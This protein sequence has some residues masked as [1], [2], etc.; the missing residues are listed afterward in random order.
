MT[1]AP[2]LPYGRQCLD[3]DDIAA[4][5][6][7]LR[8]D[9]LTGGPSV[10]RFE[11]AVA[12]YVGAPEGVACSNGTAGLHLAML[13]LGI[14]PGDV[15]VV[16]SLTFLA[17]ANA[18][19]YVGAEVVFADVDPATGLTSAAHLEAALA[20]VAAGRPRVLAPVHLNG[21]C[22]EMGEVGALARRHGLRV[23]ED[24]CHAIGAAH[25]AADGTVVRVGAC[26]QSDMAVFSMHPVKTI[27]MGEG[28]VVTTRDAE[29]AR[30]LRRFRSHGMI[31]AAE[32]VSQPG[33]G[34]AADGQPNSWYYEMLEPGFNYRATDIQC[35][36][37]LS[38]LAKIDRFLARRQAL[39]DLYDRLLAPL[40]PVVAP[41]RRI[42][43]CRPGWH[44][45]VVHIDFAALG[46]DRDAVMRRLRTAGIGTQVHYLPV[47]RQPYY[48]QRYPGTVLPGADAYYARCLSLP[49]FPAMTDGDAERVAAALAD[50][51]RC[52]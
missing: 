48:R 28:S 6:A 21:Q 49:L 50:L 12:A 52:G 23:V 44:L 3:E 19:R 5:A 4:V 20:R 46:L 29:L 43:G 38:Q 33:E 9:W 39:V 35:A 51:A 45:Y 7:V 26:P 34:L 36:L 16:P 30:R 47:H 42:P 18:A 10:A 13:A 32:G 41:I 40:A 25:V 31:P 24:A 15:V 37:G 2:F 8:G 17:T 22:V 14:G 27:A 11:Q 1:T